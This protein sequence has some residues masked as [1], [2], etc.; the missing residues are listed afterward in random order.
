MNEVMDRLFR[1]F[2]ISQ[3]QDENEQGNVQNIPLIIHINC[4]DIKEVFHDVIKIQ[5]EFEQ[6]N[7][8]N[9]PHINHTNSN[10]IERFLVM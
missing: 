7:V 3:I 2:V 8:Q 10:Y 4:N 9:I 1:T 6:G 5:H